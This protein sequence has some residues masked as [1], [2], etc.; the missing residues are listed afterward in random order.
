M[1]RYVARSMR[2]DEKMPLE[3][4]RFAASNHLCVKLGYH[5]TQRI[6]EPYSLRRT[7]D[8]NLVLHAV[9][10]DNREHRA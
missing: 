1:S 5:G 2:R 3:T 10:V 8:G 4:I 9:R 7:Q 6:I